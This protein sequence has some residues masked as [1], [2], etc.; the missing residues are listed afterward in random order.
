[1][2]HLSIH[3]QS[4]A[5]AVFFM[6]EMVRIE[7]R[8]L[9]QRK[10]SAQPYNSS[11]IWPSAAQCSCILYNVS[12]TC[13]SFPADCI[14]NSIQFLFHFTQSNTILTVYQDI[15]INNKFYHNL[16]V[17]GY[18]QFSFSLICM[19]HGNREGISNFPCSTLV[20]VD[21]QCSIAILLI[22]HKREK[23]KW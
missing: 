23:Q 9:E 20:S 13:Y 8:A 5:L 16:K 14:Y 7:R 19:F 12:N 15:Y 10:A 1:M 21:V 17:F 3:S 11:R 22:I 4:W 6:E 2:S 18:L